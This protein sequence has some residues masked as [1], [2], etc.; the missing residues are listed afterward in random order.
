MAKKTI[1]IDVLE[2]WVLQQMAETNARLEENLKRRNQLMIME[3]ESYLRALS[4]LDVYV[5]KLKQ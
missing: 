3:M 2:K 4:D 1:K 5:Q